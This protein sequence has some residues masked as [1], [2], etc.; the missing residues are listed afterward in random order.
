MDPIPRIVHETRLCGDAHTDLSEGARCEHLYGTHE[1]QVSA[2]AGMS[3]N[4]ALVPAYACVNK[5]P[6][7]PRN[8]SRRRMRRRRTLSPRRPP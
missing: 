8:R 4:I 6:L 3:T 1:E 7:Y 5:P 2:F